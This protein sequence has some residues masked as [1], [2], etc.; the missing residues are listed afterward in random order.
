[1][2]FPLSVAFSRTRVSGVLRESRLAHG[3]G[4]RK[5]EKEMVELQALL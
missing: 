2:S 3:A 1:M 5:E 4:E